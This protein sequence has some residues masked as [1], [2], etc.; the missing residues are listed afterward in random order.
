MSHTHQ[1]A[2]AQ[3]HTFLLPPTHRDERYTLK[4]EV[5]TD[6]AESAQQAQ[7]AQQRAAEAPP[8]LGPL[9]ERIMKVIA[10]SQHVLPY[11]RTA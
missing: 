11:C 4:V 7:Q 3:A 2:D 10:E 5:K 8:P 9:K 1:R 6:A